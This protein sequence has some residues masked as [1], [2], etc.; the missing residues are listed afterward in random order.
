MVLL[1]LMTCAA[2][3]QW[4]A[5]S[6]SLRSD[7]E[8]KLV[9]MEHVWAQ[10]YMAKDPKA[11]SQGSPDDAF[12]CVSS[13]GGLH[14]KA[15]VLADVRASKTLELLTESMMVRVHGDTAII[16]GIFKTVGVQHAKAFARR[17]RF[18]DTW[19]Y[20]NG[21]WTSISSVVS[22]HRGMKSLHALRLPN[23][24]VG[25]TATLVRPMAFLLIVLCASSVFAQENQGVEAAIRALEHEWVEGQSH[26][27]NHLLDLIFD[28]SLMYV[29]Y[30]RLGDPRANTC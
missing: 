18:V 29:E 1:A 19:I 30:G 11:L 13:D 10:A 25:G 17:E 14:T 9:A 20:R 6:R 22:A 7:A 27:D 12:V 23:G 4:S 2:E 16:T 5:D 21:Q 15:D 28:N 24:F 3:P 26:N 8:S